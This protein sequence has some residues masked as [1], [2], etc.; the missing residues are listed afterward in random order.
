MFHRP[1]RITGVDASRVRSASATFGLLT[2]LAAVSVIAGC[3]GD[4]PR[5]VSSSSTAS[6]GVADLLSTGAVA[7]DPAG[8]GWSALLH[9]PSHYGASTAI[10]PRTARVRWR[11]A[12]ER[13]I[14]PGPVISAAG[15]A[16]VASNGGVL[17][18]LRVATGRDIWTFNGDGRYGS[19]LS[20]SAVVLAGGTV[21]WP[22]PRHRLFALSPDG[23]LLWTLP[24]R[25]DLL[26]PVLDPVGHVLVVADGSGSING[27]RLASEAR[28][29]QR[30]WTRQLG[31]AS[32]GSPV[33]AADGSIYQTADNSLYAVS[34][35]GRP[36]WMVRTPSTVETSPAIADHGIVVFGSND[37]YEYGVNANGHVRW[38][39]P[40]GN[41]TYSSPLALAGHRVAFGNHS[42]QLTVL[43]S[44]TGARISRDQGQGQLWTAAAIDARGDAYFA[45]RT[46]QIFGFDRA[47]GRLFDFN[48][49]ST[50]F[51]SYPAL[52][53][54]GTLLVGADSGVLYAFR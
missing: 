13:S 31:S 39:V 46:G 54:D 50:T 33:V 3:G 15:V 4:G 26:T 21:L 19:D 9:G 44:D 11:R 17:H 20:T 40:I 38:R 53:P 25:A 49:G 23:R 45:S 51:D 8:A 30:L 28:Q 10:G 32:Y 37:R 27:Y 43:D 52:A 12:L 6:A 2:A 24:G 29:P 1:D 48:A 22:G 7:I 47:G 14:V 16:Y 35:A 34:P 5:A 36:R 18:A 41:F 42:G